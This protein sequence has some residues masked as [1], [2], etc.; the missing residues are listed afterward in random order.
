HE[1]LPCRLP[2]LWKVTGGENATLSD[3]ALAGFGPRFLTTTEYFS[4]APTKAGTGPTV[5]VTDRSAPEDGT[6]SATS[7]ARSTRSEPPAL[8]GWTTLPTPRP[9]TIVSVA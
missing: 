5:A 8:S 9:W 1:K 2:S 7:S 3:T 4:A 6:R